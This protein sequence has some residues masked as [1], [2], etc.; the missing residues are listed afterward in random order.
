MQFK[1]TGT[2]G[3]IFEQICWYDF[4]EQNLYTWDKVAKK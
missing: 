1:K 3:N 2:T 4:V